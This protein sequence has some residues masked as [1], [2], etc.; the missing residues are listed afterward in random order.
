MLLIRLLKAHT[1][2]SSEWLKTDSIIIA[3]KR[4]ILRQ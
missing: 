1:E 4:L 2:Q 3:G